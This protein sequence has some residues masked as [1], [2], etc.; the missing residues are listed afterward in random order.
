MDTAPDASNTNSEGLSAEAQTTGKGRRMLL[1]GLCLGVL[2]GALDQTVVGTSLPKI[3]ASIGGFEHFAWVFSA[4]ML[5]ST[6]AIPLAGKLSDLYGR[7]PVY[8]VG[9]SIFLFGSILCGLAQDMIQLVLFRGIQGIG[10]GMLFPVAMATVADIYAPAERG[11]I[12]GLIGATFGF[13]SVIGPFIG[14]W[15][16]D[17]L[18]IF[19]ISSWRWV[20]YVNMPVGA[21][22]LTV[23]LI[24]FPRLPKREV[25]PLDYLGAA[26]MTGCLSSLIL[27]TI[28]GGNTF[29]WGS[30]E[31][32]GLVSL[33]IGC[34]IGF[35][36]AE[37]RAKDPI[38]QPE[39][40]RE[41]VFTLSA[42]AQATTGI[43][44]FGVISFLPTYMQG[45]VGISATYSGA[46]L[47]PLV[48]TMVFT[49]AI[50]GQLMA[51][52]GYKVFMLL[53]CAIN[54]AGLYM[55]SILG[56]SPPIPW[57][58]AVMAFTG[59]GFGCI[60][61][62]FIIASQNVIPKKFMGS[63]TS[64]LALFRNLGTTIG[65]T[66]LG[67]L[68]NNQLREKL[69]AH[70]SQPSVD[71]LLKLPHIG[72]IENFPS[73]LVQQWFLD[74]MH[75]SHMDSVVEGI[76]AAFAESLSVLFLVAMAMAMISFII[77]MFIK[78]IPLK[79]AAEYH[80]AGPKNGA[81]K[82]EDAK[83]VTK[84]KGKSAKKVPSD[85]PKQAAKKPAPAKDEEE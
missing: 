58:I 38:V 24:Y 81:T 25:P 71:N 29:E 79:N 10:G 19:D 61:Q 33:C 82:P 3:V 52:V 74:M 26:L 13:A 18:N 34:F 62:P 8:L 27:T 44:M 67:T 36:V 55:M 7:R 78:S 51:R 2:L 17:Y 6:C 57:A 50:S 66:V 23:V 39:L 1:L 32:I 35:I 5:A 85:K 63:G 60:L 4:Y 41:R 16:V 47:L 49:A 59:L 83:P 15:I 65:I 40:F 80:G 53:G 20:F 11:K 77:S 56:T 22:A 75:A 73:L 9:M 42:L 37:R 45:V 69:P 30:P 46:V 21:L 76:K 12:Q 31:I 28:W 64:T 84:G 54:A 48:L 14:G 43:C 72:R 68:L 70:L